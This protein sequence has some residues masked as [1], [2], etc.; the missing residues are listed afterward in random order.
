M[1]HTPP[2]LPQEP[3]DDSRSVPAPLGLAKF[4]S[5]PP[6]E[7]KSVTRILSSV[8]ESGVPASAAS[9]RWNR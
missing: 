1:T 9:R 4:A 3:S 6:S 8:K 7:S 2:F 5:E